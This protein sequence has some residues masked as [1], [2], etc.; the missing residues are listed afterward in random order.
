ML[1]NQCIAMS[2]SRGLT[3]CE[4]HGKE[5]IMYKCRFCCSIAT[6]YCWGTTHFCNYH[7]DRY[8]IAYKPKSMLPYCT[9]K[10]EDCPLK[11]DHAENGDEYAIGCSKCVA[12]QQEKDFFWL[13]EVSESLKYNSVI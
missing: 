12:E 6:W 3:N 9:G 11:I 13:I 10:K 4:K 7:H 1:C 5:S 2:T 8:Q